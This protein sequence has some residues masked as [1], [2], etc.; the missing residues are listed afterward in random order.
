[1]SLKNVSGKSCISHYIHPIFSRTNR[2][3]TSFQELTEAFDGR[4]AYFKRR[5][6]NEEA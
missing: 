1:M 2:F 5:G 6:R 3:S 4:K